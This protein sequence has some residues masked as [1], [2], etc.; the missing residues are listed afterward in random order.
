MGG[1][2]T[3]LEAGATYK[4][5]SADWVKLKEEDKLEFGD[6]VNIGKDNR[7]EIILLPLCFLYLSSDTEFIYSERPDGGIE[8]QVLKG[9]ASIHS[10]LDGKNQSMVTLSAPQVKYQILEK[11][12]YRLNVDTD[13]RAEMLVYRGKVL[14]DGAELKKGRRAIV[15]SDGVKANYRIEQRTRDGF[16]V[17]SK[18]KA[19]MHLIFSREQSGKKR[20]YSPL[21]GLWFFEEISGEYT[22]FTVDILWVAVRRRQVNSNAL[23]KLEETQ[24]WLLIQIMSPR[25]QE[26]IGSTITGF[27]ENP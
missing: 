8:I 24:G 1:L 13:G 17:W 4:R 18:K 27:P 10:W 5:G 19:P 23:H 26:E 12:L 21:A 20:S 22:F 14:T 7:A 2:V 3:F 11:G 15:Q 9:A 25:L 16:D 6:V